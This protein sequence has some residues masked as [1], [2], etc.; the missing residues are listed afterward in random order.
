MLGLKVGLQ[1]VELL[2]VSPYHEKFLRHL[3]IGLKMDINQ[4]DLPGVKI[5]RHLTQKAWRHVRANIK[6]RKIPGRS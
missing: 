5:I 2:G 1:Q 3:M 6:A 4:V